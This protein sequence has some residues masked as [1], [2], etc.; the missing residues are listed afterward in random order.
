ME[1]SALVKIRFFL[2]AKWL[3]IDFGRNTLEGV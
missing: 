2:R 1:I 3:D